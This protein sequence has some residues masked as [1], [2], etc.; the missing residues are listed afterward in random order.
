MK[1]SSMKRFHVIPAV[2]LAAAMSIGSV[3]Q[4]QGPRAGGPRAGRG[5]PG[6]GPLGGLPL[7]SLNLTQ[8]QQDLIRDIRERN[9]AELQQVEAKAREAHTAQ[10]KAV[11][12]I[13]LNEA[14]IRTTTLALA[15]VQAEIAVHQARIQNDVFAALTPEQ[16]ATV[17]KARAEREQRVQAR[18]SDVRG[19]RQQKQ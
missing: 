17:T 3:A 12:A 5:G 7:A 11:N 9:R 14:A 18:Q 2:V 6:G 15:E 4:A 8:A 13:P 19:R 16:Q 1:E 10:Q